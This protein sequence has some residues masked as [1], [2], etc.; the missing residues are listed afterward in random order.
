[1][2]VLIKP[3]VTE[4][5]T[6]QNE[7]GK[8]GFIVSRDANKIDVKREVEKTYGVS[9]TSVNTIVSIGKPKTRYTRQRVVSGRTQSYKKAIVTVKEGEF[10]DFYT[11]I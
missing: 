5:G 7:K 11:G 8:Y 9:V 2:S 6:A 4:K 1:M 3:I 10:I